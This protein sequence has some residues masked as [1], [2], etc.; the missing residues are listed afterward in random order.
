MRTTLSI[1]TLMALAAFGVAAWMWPSLPDPMPTHYGVN[2]VADGF[3]PRW[4]GAL[5]IPALMLVQPPLIVG[6][7]RLDPRQEHVERIQGPLSHVLVGLQGFLLVI[8][9]LTL[10]AAVSPQPVLD[11]GV[12]IAALGVLFAVIGNA[13]GKTKSNWFFGVRTPWTLQSEA[14]W[15][16]THRIAG[17]AYV[18]AGLATL[19]LAFTTTGLV[20]VL[21]PVGL[22]LVA[23]FGTIVYSW[24]AWR[25]E[26]GTSATA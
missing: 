8:H 11:E 5:L 21:L 13:L 22:L 23:S 17:W 24:W 20:R 15:H 2:G 19:V 7:T 26:Q 3:G 9:G 18:L 25:Q 1:T 12:F 16:R 6:L 10:R 4:V 14:V